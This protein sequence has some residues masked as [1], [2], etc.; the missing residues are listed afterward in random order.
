MVKCH[1]IK[2]RV[3]PEQYERIQREAEAR[4]HKTVSAYLRFQA[5]HKDL[6]RE[7]WLERILLDIHRKVSHDELDQTRDSGMDQDSGTVA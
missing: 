4:G 1:V 3:T 5:L 7:L 6:N 2:F